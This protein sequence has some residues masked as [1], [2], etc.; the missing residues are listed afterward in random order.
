MNHHQLASSGQKSRHLYI[1]YITLMSFHTTEGLKLSPIQQ[2]IHRVDIGS[3]T[4]ML[5][6]AFKEAYAYIHAERL[7]QTDGEASSTFELSQ[8]GAA[9]EKNLNEQVAK[10]KASIDRWSLLEE[11]LQQT[12]APS[13]SRQYKQVSI[14]SLSTNVITILNKLFF[15]NTYIHAGCRRGKSSS[16]GQSSTVRTAVSIESTG[17]HSCSGA[18]GC[19][20]IS[21]GV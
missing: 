9:S 18:T 21:V 16:I 7:S 12:I 1:L 8:Q 6:V 5:H 14:Y 19:V 10:L 11:K 13:S 17:V 3:E 4:Q 2:Q 20:S 15:F